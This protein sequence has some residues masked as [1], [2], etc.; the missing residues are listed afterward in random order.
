MRER[1]ICHSLVTP[2]MAAMVK[3]GP[4]QSQELFP[5]LHVGVVAEARGCRGPA[6]GPSFATFPSTS[7]GS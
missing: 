6:L 7:A 1:E 4:S 5:G 2:Q 3:A